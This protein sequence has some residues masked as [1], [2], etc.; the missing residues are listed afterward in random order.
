M[1]R[2]NAHKH[3]KT[4][5]VPVSETG[6]LLAG[7][8][9]STSPSYVLL[10]ILTLVCLAPFLGKAFHIDDTLFLL[11]ARQIVKHPF[12]P[13]GFKVVWYASA[14]PMSVVTKNPPMASYYIAAVASVFGWSER[15]LH[16]ALMLPAL[17]CVLG[18]YRL[19]QHFTRTPL[20]AALAAL[21]TPGFVVSSTNIM[22]D[23]MML[24]LW[25][26][27]IILWL[28]GM[29]RAKPLLFAMSGLLIAICAL[30]KYFGMALIPLLLAYSLARQRRVGL[31]ILSLLL[32]IL[33]LAWYQHWTQ[34]VYGRGLLWDA[35]EYART[36]KVGTGG[37]PAKTLVGLAFT[38]GC[39]LTSVT[40]IPLLWPKRWV[41][42]SVALAALIG[43]AVALAWIQIPASASAQ[44][45]WNWVS[46]QLA[47]FLLGGGV[48]LALAIEDLWR[49]RDAD[50]LLLAMWVLGT[51]V[52]AAFVNWT[53]NVRSVLPLTPALG[54]L[55]ARRL[56]LSGTNICNSFPVKVAAALALSGFVSLWVA[57]GDAELANSERKAALS[58]RDRF[59]NRVTDVSFEGH[60][61]FQY[62]MQQF[63][64][65]PLDT[66][67]YE[68]KA[69]SLLIIPQ[70]NS[71][72]FGVEQRFVASRKLFQFDVHAGAATMQ[73]DMGAG[74][75][76]ALWG[77][78]PYAFGSAAP[79]RYMIVELTEP[80][81]EH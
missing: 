45:Q 19:A 25:V 6:R 22:C 3:K 71:N 56:D 57:V 15:V 35:A 12:D 24:A 28:E 16:L 20:V 31:W 13:Y 37:V 79:E 49:R 76:T 53:I 48:T 29:D 41:G 42:A 2:Q 46:V 11:A 52:F 67:A 40:F 72:V 74:F 9:T 32:P 73:R 44:E 39:A 4:G 1:V 7:F 60:W 5:G 64:F 36:L 34:E 77:P 65:E 80:S 33:A 51:F 68:L 38:G 23:T 8:S 70:N 26:A 66:Q 61:G 18:T 17:V 50:S 27:A 78:L 14:M 69:G 63:G 30:T 81:D 59:A 55:L 54:I 10:T 58:V 75:Y 62:Y 47:L 21:L 43:V